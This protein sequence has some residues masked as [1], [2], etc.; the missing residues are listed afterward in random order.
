MQR[1][2]HRVGNARDSSEFL[3]EIAEYIPPVFVDLLSG[4]RWAILRPHAVPRFKRW[5]RGCFFSRDQKVFENLSYKTGLR[6]PLFAGSG[7]ESRVEVVRSLMFKVIRRS[8][9][10]PFS[11]MAMRVSWGGDGG[12]HTAV[13]T[14]PE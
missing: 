7:F 6:H 14:S 4:R 5:P 9:C 8:C 11:V 10:F 12:R 1:L 3:R 2:E 13:R